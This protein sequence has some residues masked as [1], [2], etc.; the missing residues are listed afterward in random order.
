[1]AINGSIRYLGKHRTNPYAVHPPATET[2][3]HG[4]YLRPKALCYVD[5]WYV[6]FAVL[7]AYHAGTYSP[8]DEIRFKQY[9]PLDDLVLGEFCQRILTDFTAHAY[10]QT[11]AQQKEKT[12]AEIY[13]LFYEW[14][15]GE[16]AKKKLS[17]QSKYSTQAAFKNLS[18]LHKK[19]F[20]DLRH[21]DYQDLIDASPLK[22][23]ST[24][25]MVSLIKQM[26]K[27]ALLYELCDRDFS[28]SLTAHPDDDE[29]G[30]PFTDSDLETLWLHQDDPT[31]E[32][33]LIM[34]YSGFRITAYKTIEVNTG[35]WYFRG[36]IKTAA[37]KSRI[38]PI[39]SAI[40]GL[41]KRRM[42][43][44][45]CILNE[46]TQ[47]FRSHMYEALDALGIEKHTP[48]D[49]RHTFSALCEK[50]GVNE[51]DRKRML[52]HS[53]GSD[54]TN[55]VYGHRTLQELRTEI[56]KI[57]CDY[58]VSSVGEKQEKSQ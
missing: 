9:R 5:D 39:H 20:K 49:C 38:V 40:Q 32:F 16:N 31:V 42:E 10:V 56:E 27:Y 50:Y 28:G 3:D 36:G 47:A 37:G 43:R 14:K 13:E 4:N 15:Y 17:E 19:V 33:I 52:G 12:F 41:V 26:Y 35:E 30:V 51:N 29:H 18:A 1:M 8:G 55:A 22:S 2:D 7:N 58:L 34:C 57:R 24:E 54:V 45:G 46:S 23:A 6:G 44:D 48:H 25:N 11:E 53:F 21:K